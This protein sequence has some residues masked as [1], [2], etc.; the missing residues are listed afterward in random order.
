MTL[1]RYVVRWSRPLMFQA[2][3]A[4][5]GVVFTPAVVSSPMYRA[6]EPHGSHYMS[7]QTSR[8][9]STEPALLFHTVT[10]MIV[11]IHTAEA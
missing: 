5:Q 2:H 8:I 9:C 11:F 6:R 1:E 4:W 3:N 10:F 7:R